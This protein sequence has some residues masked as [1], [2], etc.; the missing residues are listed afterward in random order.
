MTVKELSQLYWL[1]KEI[2]RD[3]KRL[4][5][6]EDR[7][8]SVPSPN[9]SGMPRGGRDGN[10]VELCAE[11]IADLKAIIEAKQKQCIY[12]KKR[13]ERYIA[14]I[15]DSLTRQIFALRFVDGRSWSGVADEVGGNNS[16]ESV[17]KVCYRFLKNNQSCPE[18]PERV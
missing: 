13:L 10:G 5:E 18:C 9:L 14:D 16:E 8:S 12:E 6:L 11:D 3:K 2:E 17:K 15:P 7:A 4:A 1:N